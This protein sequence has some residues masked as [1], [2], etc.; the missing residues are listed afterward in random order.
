[1]LEEYRDLWWRWRYP[2]ASH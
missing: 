2:N 1:M